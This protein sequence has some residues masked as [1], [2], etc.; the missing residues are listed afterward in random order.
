MINTRKMGKDA[1]RGIRVRNWVL[2][3][4]FISI[5]FAIGDVDNA[6]TRPGTEI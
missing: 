5:F 6:N 2:E 4:P 1:P 3:P